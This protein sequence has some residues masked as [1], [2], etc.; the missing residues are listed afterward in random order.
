MLRQDNQTIRN[1]YNLIIVL[2]LIGQI[3]LLAMFDSI[4][5]PLKTV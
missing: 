5:K 1:Y 3:V 4:T 2:C